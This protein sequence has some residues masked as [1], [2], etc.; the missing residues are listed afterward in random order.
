MFLNLESEI[1]KKMEFIKQMCPETKSLLYQFK[2]TFPNYQLLQQVI[3][4]W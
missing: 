3:L 1:T 2:G 4:S